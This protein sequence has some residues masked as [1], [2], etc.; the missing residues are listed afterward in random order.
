ME[1]H[2]ITTMLGSIDLF[3]GLSQ[4]VLKKIVESGHVAEYEGGTA[5]VSQGDSVEGFKAF[6]STGVE[7]HVV[8]S[9]SAVVQV[10]G[11]VVATLEPGAYFG[12]LSLIDGGPRSADV[13]AHEDGLQ[14]LALPKWT[15]D[16]LLEKHPEVAV[17][18][19]RVVCGRL[20]R[21]EAAASR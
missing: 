10:Q 21:A 2:E 8:L 7:M 16:N 6:S 20:R 11:A 19:L 5:V 3:E 12:E 4:R 13:V 15:F 17:P 18:M 14:T 9:G 1:T